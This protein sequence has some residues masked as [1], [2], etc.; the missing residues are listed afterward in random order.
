MDPKQMA[1]SGAN[2]Y[3]PLVKFP[4]TE[5]TFLF[6]F[7]LTGPPCVTHRCPDICKIYLYYAFQEQNAPIQF[8]D[9]ATQQTTI[10]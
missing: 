5:G 8:M 7:F 2:S 3:I 6:Y 4:C 1:T 10:Y 9:V